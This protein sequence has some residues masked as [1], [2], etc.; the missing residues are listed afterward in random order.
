M[1]RP[2][3]LCLAA[4]A[5][6]VSIP[7]ARTAPIAQQNSSDGLLLN[8]TSAPPAGSVIAYSGAPPLYQIAWPPVVGFAGGLPPSS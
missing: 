5:V 7:G 1:P 4:L 3:C 6:V 2:F 8:T